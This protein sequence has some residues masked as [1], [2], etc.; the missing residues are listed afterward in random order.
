MDKKRKRF[1]FPPKEYGAFLAHLVNAETTLAAYLVLFDNICKLFKTDDLFLYEVNEIKKL[2][3]D[4]LSE[5]NDTERRAVA[6]KMREAEA[7]LVLHEAPDLIQDT[8]IERSSSEEDSKILMTQE[9]LL[10]S[11]LHRN[12]WIGQKTYCLNPMRFRLIFLIND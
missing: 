1:S 8:I 4:F 7:L 5:F 2:Y 10:Y 12:T 11:L 9:K 6:L 3:D